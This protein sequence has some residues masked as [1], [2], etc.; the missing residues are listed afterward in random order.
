MNARRP[1]LVV[2]PAWFRGE[3][4]FGVFAEVTIAH[5]QV[6]DALQVI[7]KNVQ[8]LAA[9]AV[10]AGRAKAM[11]DGVDG[12]SSRRASAAERV[13]RSVR[14][15]D[16]G[17][18]VRLRDV[19]VATP[20]APAARAF[21][22]PPGG[23]DACAFFRPGGFVSLSAR[24]AY[25]A[26]AEAK[27]AEAEPNPGGDARASRSR[28][29]GIAGPGARTLASGLSFALSAGDALLVRGPTGCGKSS[30]LRVLAGLWPAAAG[31]LELDATRVFVPQR[32]YLA[33][34]SL[35]DQLAYVRRADMSLM[36]RGDAA[37]A[38][39]IF[40]GESS[41]ASGIPTPRS[42]ATRT[43]RRPRSRRSASATWRPSSTPS[44]TGAR[45]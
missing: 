40:R 28:H 31:A 4:G 18:L 1:A 2:G 33:L 32:P 38:T 10:A 5:Q 30:L 42:P 39:R 6:R 11:R 20:G 23:D 41:R 37:V 14:V 3:V 27:V 26:K 29:G 36:D 16:G 17:A 9:V 22:L 25:D 7:A 45:A 43:R 8:G 12:V 21:F 34:G 44:T 24:A 19:R 35:S 13:A 15:P